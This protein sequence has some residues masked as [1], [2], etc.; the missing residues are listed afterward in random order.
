[1]D[2]F[3]WLREHEDQAGSESSQVPPL[4]G[5][6][7]QTSGLRR[8]GRIPGTLGAGCWLGPNPTHY[9]YKGLQKLFLPSTQKRLLWLGTNASSIIPR[10][11]LEQEGCASTLET[12]TEETGRTEGVLLSTGDALNTALASST[13][14]SLQVREGDPRSADCLCKGTEV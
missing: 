5:R 14:G 3:L 1:M 4:R 10:V 2:Q 12:E 7:A 6:G 8:H 11:P 13:R 9:F